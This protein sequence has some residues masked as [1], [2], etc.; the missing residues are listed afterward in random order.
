VKPLEARR[1]HL[2]RLQ[3][4]FT[5]AELAIVTAIVALLLGGMMAMVSAQTDQRNWN[6][7][8]SRLEAARDAI[9]GYAIVNGRLPCPANSTSAGAEVRQTA[10]G[11][12]QYACGAPGHNPT[13]NPLDYYGGVVPGTPPVTYGLMP[14]VTVGY[15]PVDTQGFA[16]D[17]WGNR[18]RYAVS[19][20]NYPNF[21]NAS[22]LKASGISFQPGDL[23]VCASATGIV[24]S[25]PSCGTAASVTNQNT[26][27]AILY[28]PGKNGRGQVTL[29]TDETAN[30]NPAAANDAV[31]VSHPPTPSTTPAAAGGEFDDQVLWISVGTLYSKLIAAQLLP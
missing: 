23:V 28:S 10:I 12:Y 7:T 29:G 15:L 1:I 11:P 14:A 25:P 5:L 22:T 3:P 27:V 4:G 2:P 6:D 24:S 16:M 17:A 30:G 26:V 31:F 18:I 20:T 8:Q 13:T 21:T 9:L 19:A